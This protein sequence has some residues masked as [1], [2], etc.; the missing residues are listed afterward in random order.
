MS[1]M[2]T[3]PI[4]EP[5][6]AILTSEELDPMFRS[7]SSPAFTCARTRACSGG[8]GKRHRRRT[9]CRPQ[10]DRDCRALL[11]HPRYGVEQTVVARPGELT[12]VPR[13]LSESNAPR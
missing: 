9:P 13:H 4:P 12:A 1:S 5:L 10:P 7:R 6:R 8:P 3:Q 11:D 2:G